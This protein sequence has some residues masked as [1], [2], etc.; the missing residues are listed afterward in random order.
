MGV[1][2]DVHVYMPDINRK[3]HQH[4]HYEVDNTSNAQ[5]YSHVLVKL[6]R[7]KWCQLYIT[8]GYFVLTSGL[9]DLYCEVSLSVLTAEYRHTTPML[10]EVWCS[11]NGIFNNSTAHIKTTQLN[12]HTATKRWTTK[13]CRILRYKTHPQLITIDFYP[14][15]K[16]D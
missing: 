7:W 11:S 12:Y 15:K 10:A 6:E 8:G 9:F 5:L 13:T 16:K 14:I 3:H 4:K 1:L 2:S